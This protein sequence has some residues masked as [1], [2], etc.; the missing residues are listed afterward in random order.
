M[1]VGD[2]VEIKPPASGY[3]WSGVI[4]EHYMIAKEL[5][6]MILRNDTGKVEKFH[7]K[8]CKVINESR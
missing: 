3:V 6:Y 2:L 1:K 8:W 7:S 4:I 5:W